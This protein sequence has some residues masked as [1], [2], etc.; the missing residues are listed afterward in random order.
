MLNR[1]LIGRRFG[2]GKIM[3]DDS[4]FDYLRVR[5]CAPIYTQSDSA[6]KNPTGTCLQSAAR[7]SVEKTRC[8]GKVRKGQRV[9]V[10]NKGGETQ[11]EP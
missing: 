11:H 8:C 4:R 5:R 6:A 2:A 7:A 3:W 10:V 1:C 9:K